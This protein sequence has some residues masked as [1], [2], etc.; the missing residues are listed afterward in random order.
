MIVYHQRLLAAVWF[1]ALALLCVAV[2]FH[3]L[4]MS[5]HGILLYV[6][7]PVIASGIAGSLWGITILNQAKTN[8]ILLSLLRG[9][10]VSSGA[11]VIF[12]LMFALALPFVER[13]WSL[14]QSES[15][16]FFT[17][18]LG[19]LL[20]GPIVLFGGMLGGAMLYLF[21]RRVIRE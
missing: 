14:R 15:L 16:L 8:S 18:S 11:F 19:L 6:F 1:A 3:R 9:V 10:A 2:M 12:S 4:T 7:L 17:W 20:V 5:F 21:G 13:G